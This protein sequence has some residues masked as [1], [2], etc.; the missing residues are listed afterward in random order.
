MRS[1]G[2][3]RY[4]NSPDQECTPLQLTV[5]M[6]LCST[7]TSL[8]RSLGTAGSDELL[9]RGRSSRTASWTS[10]ARAV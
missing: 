1:Q 7:G 2:G 3:S 5:L 8:S 10:A 6:L 9:G 4:V